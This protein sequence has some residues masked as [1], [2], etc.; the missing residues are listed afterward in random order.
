MS[1]VNFY[2][3]SHIKN[4]ALEKLR[5]DVDFT[6]LVHVNDTFL[7]SLWISIHSSFTADGNCSKKTPLSVC[8]FFAHPQFLAAGSEI[9]AL[10]ENR[11]CF[12]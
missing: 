4:A 1:N 10:F 11:L 12:N 9:S 6:I 2:F 3:K 8:L 7:N 5:N